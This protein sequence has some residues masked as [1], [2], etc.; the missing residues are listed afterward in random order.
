MKKG[1]RIILIFILIFQLTGSAGW[2]AV[3]EGGL[4]ANALFEIGLHYYN[5][6]KYADAIHELN[7]VLLIYPAHQSAKEN[8]ELIQIEHIAVVGKEGFPPIAATLPPRERPLI[9]EE[10]LPPIKEGIAPPIKI[11][12]EE[13]VERS[14]DEWQIKIKPTEVPEIQ[15]VPEEMLLPEPEMIGMPLPK[16]IGEIG[17]FINEQEV[18]LESPIIIEEEKV[19]VPL[20]DIA[21]ALNFGVIDLGEGEFRLISPEGVSQEVHAVFIKGIP[22]LSQEDLEEYFAVKSG[23]EPAEK[24]FFVFSK[25]PPKFQTYLVKSEKKEPAEA[26]EELVSDEER[27]LQP[28]PY[29][30]KAA[31]PDV[32]MTGW[33]SYLNRDYHLYSTYHSQNFQLQGRLYDYHIKYHTHWKDIRGKV[34]HDYTHF[35][36]GHDDMSLK[37]FDQAVYLRNVRNQSDSFEGINFTKKWSPVNRTSFLGGDIENYAYG[38]SGS[39]KYQG[40]ILG[41]EQEYKP[42]EWWDSKGALFYIQN[43][44]EPDALTGTTSYPRRNLVYFLDNKFQISD[45]LSLSNQLAQC[46]YNPD[47]ASD[48]TINDIDWRLGSE[49]YHPR[50]RMKFDYEFVGDEY[51]SLGN[52]LSYQDY[53]GW[54]L[55]TDYK[56]TDAWRLSGILSRYQ[57]NVDD[58]PDKTTSK[59]QAFS[60]FSSH[61]ILKDQSISLGFSR[62]DSDSSGPT[63]DINSQTDLY[64]IDYFRPFLLNTSLFLNYQYI[65]MD[66]DGGSDH[67]THSQGIGLVKSFG[68]GSSWHIHQDIAK[69]V[70]E[71]D[72]NTLDYNSSFN[73]YYVFNPRM[74]MNFN[75]TYTR[76]KI[77][78]NESSKRL[79]GSTNLSYQVNPDTRLNLEYAVN[80]YDPDAES[81]WPEDW[82]IMFYI[83]QGFGIKTPPNFGELRG[84][85]ILDLN[86]NDKI[87]P[88]EPGVEGAGLKLEDRR[89]VRTDKEGGFR[90]A[91][92]TPGIQKVVLDLA[93]LPLEWTSK[94][95]EKEV[96][97][98]PR[99]EAEVTF[100]LIKASSIRG[101]LFIDAN[102]DRIFQAEEEPL[103]DITV[104]LLPDEKSS[105]TDSEGNFRFDYLIPGNYTIK[106]YSETLPKG[107]RVVSDEEREF[108]LKSGQQIKDCNFSLQWEMPIQK[109]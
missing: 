63:T 36:L 95:L 54:N 104:L 4:A 76:S 102:N 45:E 12:R 2:P 71:D 100:L 83:R 97:V 51:A 21:K 10:K 99:R 1:V 56:M 6:G 20:Y 74:R 50:G 101:R 52:P 81:G 88:G 96:E 84:K 28:P 57:N 19:F 25:T 22:T 18:D 75:S 48:E 44:A 47:N 43:H 26:E 92:V 89:R 42:R 38:T 23:Y 103:D 61:Q 59:S 91:Y 79:R 53:K 69:T 93:D 13:A 72:P 7:K 66:S 27:A 11:P 62:F 30:P 35:S 82:S 60:L 24:A 3:M 64:R 58:S 87:D 37:L 39:V 86:A 65:T 17:L 41:I 15:P 33:I 8:I 67:L 40:Q 5:Q 107:C 70:Y 32:D 16:R 94:A 68:R 14:L 108:K 31:Q 73:L 46:N 78:G 90:F 55:Y 49:W 105:H 80:T 9:P 34:D 85:V 98:R 29:I 106:I 109:F 77:K